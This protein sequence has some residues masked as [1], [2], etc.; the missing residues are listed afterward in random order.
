MANGLQRGTSAEVVARHL[1]TAIECG[2]YKHQQQLPSTRTLAQEWGTS[3]A[4]ITRAMQMLAAEGLVQSR[5]RSS[6]IVN[7]PGPEQRPATQQASP[8]V[9]LIGGYAGSGKT[10]LGRIMARLTGWPILDKDSTTRPVVEAALQQLG[11]S[12]HD[13]ESELYLS[14]IRPAEYE[15]LRTVTAENLSCGNSVIMTAPFVKELSDPTWARRIEADVEAMNARLYTI[16][17]RCDLDSMHTYLKRRG[18]ARDAHKLA[19]W[20]D[21][22]NNIDTDFTPAMPHIIVNNSLSSQ[23]LQDQ[24]KNLIAKWR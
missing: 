13:R 24:A 23:P 21:Y 20:A 5:D 1:R 7:H 8:T 14:V 12:P 19:N 10:E 3:V 15:A 6:R 22:L 9:V 11:H 4:T 18:A 16:W 2:D 17:V